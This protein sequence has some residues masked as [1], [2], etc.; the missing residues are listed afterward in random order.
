[1]FPFPDDPE[2]GIQQ[3]H[4]LP[5]KNG[6]SAPSEQDRSLCAAPE[7][8]DDPFISR[9]EIFHGRRV[10]IIDIPDGQTDHLR[11]DLP[12]G[13][14]Y[15]LL[16]AGLVHVQ[17][18]NLVPRRQGPDKIIEAQRIDRVRGA[19]R[20][21]GNQKH[22]HRLETPIPITGSPFK[23]DVLHNP[24]ELSMPQNSRSR[25]TISVRL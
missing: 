4:Q 6:K 15:P 5:R 2:I 23:T 22:S 14:L 1:M 3:G 12:H 16:S 19:G 25:I 20:I 11:M 10:H 13:R 7:E 17:K 18:V 9:N 24:K 8:T 21:G